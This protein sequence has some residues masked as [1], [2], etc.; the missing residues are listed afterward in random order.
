[1][2][3]RAS[4]SF[5]KREEFWKVVVIIIVVES[6]LKSQSRAAVV[7]ARKYF[8][9]PEKRERPPLEAVT[10]GQMKTQQPEKTKCVP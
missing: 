3:P 6:F 8:G 5:Y 10:R 4:L 2:G 1:V 9:N 7:K